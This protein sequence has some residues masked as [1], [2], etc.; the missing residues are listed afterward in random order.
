MI[1]E[2]GRCHRP[3]ES[4]TEI[5]AM[6]S[7]EMKGELGELERN[8]TQLIDSKRRTDSTG[9]TPTLGDCSHRPYTGTYTDAYTAPIPLVTPYYTGTY[10]DS[11]P[12][13]LVWSFSSP[14]SPPHPPVNGSRA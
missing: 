8:L 10:T 3:T 1:E 4:I 7:D 14:Q 12:I 9:A 11:T 6:I 13:N 2:L 5:L